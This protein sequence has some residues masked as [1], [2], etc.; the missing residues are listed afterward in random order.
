MYS[1]LNRLAKNMVEYVLA[2][3]ATLTNQ[4]RKQLCKSAATSDSR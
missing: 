1:I 4:S 2:I 3:L